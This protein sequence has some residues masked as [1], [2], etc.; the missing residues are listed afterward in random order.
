MVSLTYRQIDEAK[1][2]DKMYQWA[3]T[4]TSSGQNMPFSLPLR[5]KKL[6]GG[7]EVFFTHF[8]SSIDDNNHDH[9][10]KIDCDSIDILGSLRSVLASSLNLSIFRPWYEV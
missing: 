1:F 7:F 10:N 6:P 5:I 8:P 9:V 3:A 4:L 2:A